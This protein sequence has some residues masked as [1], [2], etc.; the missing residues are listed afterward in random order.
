M[1]YPET[2][3]AQRDTFHLLDAKSL[4]IRSKILKINIEMEDSA[5]ACILD[6]PPELVVDILTT[7][8]KSS[9]KRFRLVSKGCATLTAPLLFE[10]IYFDFDIGGTNGLVAISRQPELCQHVHTVE[11]RRRDGLRSFDDTDAW[12]AATV[13]EYAFDTLEDG[14]VEIPAGAM[15]HDEWVMLPDEA[16]QK[17]YDAYESDRQAVVGYTSRL[18][19]ALSAIVYDIHEQTQTDVVISGAHKTLADFGRAIARLS[20]A[21]HFVHS[22]RYMDDDWGLRWRNVQFHHFGIIDGSTG[23]DEDI[24]NIQLFAALH[25][26]MLSTD[27]VTSIQL[28]TRGHAFW[29]A[30]HLRRLLDWSE[31]A[32]L[33]WDPVDEGLDQWIDAIGGPLRACQ[34]IEAAT[35]HL[36]RIESAFSRLAT[37]ECSV[38]TVGADGSSELATIAAALSNMLQ[39]ATNLQSL[40]LSFLVLLQEPGLR[41]WCRLLRTCLRESFDP[42]R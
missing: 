5:T 22:S 16:V 41:H 35:R 42:K 19:C 32:G 9:Q 31:R 18:S 37:L 36:V 2:S 40:Q 21:S 17:L 12:R 25:S 20:S 28:C 26:I 24:D 39:Q 6:L 3:C 13:Y 29:S 8:D 11:L 4:D 33:R 1:C 30:A 10:H 38:D 34:H 7:L 23:A 15:T 27:T 14:D